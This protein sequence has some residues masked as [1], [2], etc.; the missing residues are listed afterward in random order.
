MTCCEAD[1]SDTEMPREKDH[2]SMTELEAPINGHPEMDR[3]SMA[4]DNKKRY[5]HHRNLIWSLFATVIG[6]PLCGVVAV[7][8]AITSADSWDYGDIKDSRRRA[9]LS[10]RWSMYSMCT[11]LLVLAGVVAAVVYAVLG[12]MPMMKDFKMNIGIVGPLEVDIV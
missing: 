7:Y 9:R 10:M 4:A 8:Y 12:L 6:C 5:K 2:M 1:D 3:G 11:F